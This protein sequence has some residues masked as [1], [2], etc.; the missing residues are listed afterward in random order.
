MKFF[1]IPDKTIITISIL[2][3][4]GIYFMITY[5]INAHNGILLFLQF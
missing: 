1:F 3:A 4:I 2:C 5:V